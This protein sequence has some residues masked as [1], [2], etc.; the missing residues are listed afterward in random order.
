IPG[1]VGGSQ[2]AFS[3]D[4]RSLAFFAER[5]LKRVPSA[6]GAVETVA[7]VGGNPR[8]ATWGEDG[9]IVVAP[10]Q[11]SGLFRVPSSG[12]ALQPL[13][14]L[15]ES[16]GEN[17]HR[18]PQLLPGGAHALF[19]VAGEGGTF[20]EARVEAVSLATGQRKRV[21]EGGA[22]ARYVP[23]GHL[24]FA[25]GGRLFAVPFNPVR[26]ETRGTPQVVVEGVRYDAQNGGT[27]FAVSPVGGLV[28]GPAAV[29]SSEH[30]L[31]L[32]D[33]ARRI[34]R[35]G[36]TPRAYREPKLSPDGRRAAVVIGGAA[37]SALWGG[38][39]ARVAAPA[40]D[41]DSRRHRH[42]GGRA[43]GFGL[44]ARHG[45]ARRQQNPRGRPRDTAPRLSQ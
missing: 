7:E 16:A 27:H 43:E 30:P 13:T 12:G 11:T 25:R 21:L 4:G 23:S 26:L 38:D 17:S 10:H 9:T 20:D 15:E 18:W 24:V 28:Y 29:T 1:T 22:H 32:V 35:V 34:I 19:T 39:G 5:K 14:R 36:E 33:A 2:P 6:G 37:D 40:A 3:P 8:G 31:S 41:V 42:H 44:G 45:A